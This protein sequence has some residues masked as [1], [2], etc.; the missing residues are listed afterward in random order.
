MQRFNRLQESDTWRDEVV[1]GTNKPSLAQ[2]AHLFTL[3]A[4][5]AA[6]EQAW[7]GGVAAMAE[8]L[9]TRALL[10][11]QAGRSGRSRCSCACKANKERP[12]KFNSEPF[13]I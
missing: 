3:P 11:G 6:L 13:R 10:M 12:S 4:V 8:E 9:C 1:R 2:A 7:L 5:R